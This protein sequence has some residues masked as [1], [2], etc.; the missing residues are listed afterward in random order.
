MNSSGD[1]RPEAAAIDRQG[2][3]RGDDGAPIEQ[4]QRLLQLPA[5]VPAEEDQTARRNG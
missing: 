1:E 3:P 4:T 5:Q 2:Q